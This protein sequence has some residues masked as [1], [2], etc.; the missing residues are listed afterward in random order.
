[1]R[2]RLHSVRQAVAELRSALLTPSVAAPSVALLEAQLPALHAAVLSLQQLRAESPEPG[3]CGELEALKR[4]LRAPARLIA[5]GLAL[6]QRMARQLA[7][8]TAGYQQDGQP[9]ALKA[10]GTLLVRG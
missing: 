7:S 2:P 6:S 1:M 9:A 10:G 4:E 8:T 3:L 5:Q